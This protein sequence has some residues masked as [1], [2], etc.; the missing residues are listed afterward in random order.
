MADEMTVVDQIEHQFTYH[1][2]TERQ[3][4]DMKEIRDTAKELAHLI[5]ARCPASAD[6]TV[7][8]RK[9]REAVMI[10]NASIVLGGK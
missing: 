7:A 4:G 5:A 8:I 9:I 6:R 2:P 3:V 1:A 10:A